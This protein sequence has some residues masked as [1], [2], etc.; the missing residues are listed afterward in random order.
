[1]GLNLKYG[2]EECR[3]RVKP[4][5]SRVL[6]YQIEATVSSNLPVAAHLTLIPHLKE[7]LA[8]GGGER[9]TLDESPFDFTSQQ[10]GGKLTHAGY[11]LHLPESTTLHWPALPHNPYRKDGSATAAEGRIELR[12]PFD[13]QNSNYTVT[14]EIAEE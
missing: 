10:V 5:N 7:T 4:R 9:I 12:I 11:T 3:I 1:V 6:E 2:P 13:K 14:M 8:T